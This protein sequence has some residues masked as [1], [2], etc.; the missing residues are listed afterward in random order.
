MAAAGPL[1]LINDLALPTSASSPFP[2]LYSDMGMV[3]IGFAGMPGLTIGE[4]CHLDPPERNL[5]ESEAPR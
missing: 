3:V 1:T 2:L 5:S 4:G